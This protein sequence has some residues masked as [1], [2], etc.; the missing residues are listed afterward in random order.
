MSRSVWVAPT[1]V[2]VAGLRIGIRAQ[3]EEHQAWLDSLLASYR[4]DD[5]DVP[6]NYSVQVSDDR[7]ALHLLYWGGCLVARCRTRE[8]LVD[9]IAAHLG[10][11]GPTPPGVARLDGVLLRHGS[12]GVILTH[13]DQVFAAKLLGRLRR[14][15]VGA[16]QRPWIDVD[17]ARMRVLPAPALALDGGTGRPPESLDASVIFMPQGVVERPLAD[18]VLLLR[19]QRVLQLEAGSLAAAVQLLCTV[20]TERVDDY[21]VDRV[22]EQLRDE[23][24]IN[25]ASEAA[26]RG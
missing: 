18:R 1:A 13:V 4:V 19:Q 6:P 9:A 7:T 24:L 16:E 26:Q 2:E 8:E 17:A 10:G 5:P 15:G 22:A 14:L 20:R 23:F 11:H 3:D 25:P 21:A 12:K